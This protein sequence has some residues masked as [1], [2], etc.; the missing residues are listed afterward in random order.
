MF[1]KGLFFF[2]KIVCSWGPGIHLHIADMI[3][4]FGELKE[5]IKEKINR[6][7]K[8]FY[9][10]AISPDITLGKKYIKEAEKHSH[11]WETGFNVAENAETESEYVLGLGY[12]THLAADVIA[13]NFFLPKQLL[14]GRG[15]RSFSHT[16]IEIKSDMILYKET[17]EIIKDI[18]SQ[19]YNE[20]DEY[21]K[22]IISKSIIPF[23]V[24]RKIFDY[25]LKSI[26][27]KH[28]YD[29][30]NII[31]NHKERHEE[32]REILMEYHSI[33]YNAAIDVIANFSKA[34]VTKYDP[35]GYKHLE[36]LK[37]LRKE[38]RILKIKN[39]E[40][41]FYKIPEELRK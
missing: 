22:N 12:L 20:E 27:N 23:G 17:N 10:G 24:N 33:S 25:S 26:K 9:Y 4:K 14:S 36:S 30:S 2:D 21:L 16:I 34:A 19:N 15:L 28:F 13:H 3:L 11:I 39:Y 41:N 1:F 37:D 31:T 38:Y 35:N 5:D 7:K 18:L 32:N 6:N 29:W 8:Q 40:E